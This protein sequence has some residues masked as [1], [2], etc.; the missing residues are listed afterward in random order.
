MILACCLGNRFQVSVTTLR[1]SKRTLSVLSDVFLKYC[2]AE[3][4]EKC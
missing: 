1:Q 4:G 3:F 2:T